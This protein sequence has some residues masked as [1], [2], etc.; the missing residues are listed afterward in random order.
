MALASAMERQ[1]RVDTEVHRDTLMLLSKMD[2]RIDKEHD[3]RMALTADLR[4]LATKVAIVG[5]L[6]LMVAQIAGPVIVKLFVP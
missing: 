6:A 2:E 5:G 1:I 4:A 3:E